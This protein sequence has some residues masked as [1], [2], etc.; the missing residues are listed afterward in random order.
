MPP[1]SLPP[2]LTI[3]PSISLSPSFSPQDGQPSDLHTR[4]S[5][6]CTLPLRILKVSVERAAVIVAVVWVVVAVVVIALA[7][8]AVVAV[9]AA[10][11]V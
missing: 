5:I 11:A 4:E 9:V 10:V 1:Y 6:Y 2:S 8:V 3:T 7:V